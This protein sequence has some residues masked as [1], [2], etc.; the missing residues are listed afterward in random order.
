MRTIRVLLEQAA[1]DRASLFV[2]LAPTRSFKP[3]RVRTFRAPSACIA[4]RRQWQCRCVV[5]CC[6]VRVRSRIP[7]P[8]SPVLLLA[9][10]LQSRTRHSIA[11]MSN[12]FNVCVPSQWTS[13]LPIL[14]PTDQLIN[15]LANS[16]IFPCSAFKSFNSGLLSTNWT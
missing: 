5:L 12:S 9:R 15:Q 2:V 8:L 4:H 13:D 14:G 1:R 7:L 6:V 10:R 11:S 16:E 3:S